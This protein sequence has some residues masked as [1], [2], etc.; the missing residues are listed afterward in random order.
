MIKKENK[1]FRKIVIVTEYAALNLDLANIY[2]WAD[3]WLVRFN[4][5]KSES[6]LHSRKRWKPYPP[7]VLLNRPKL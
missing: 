4:P 7:Q 2:R 6:I 3:K 1:K 5:G